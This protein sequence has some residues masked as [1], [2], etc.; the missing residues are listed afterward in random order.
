MSSDLLNSSF[1][2]GWNNFDCSMSFT[3]CA[4]YIRV[5]KQ[6]K[7]Q[8]PV[9][10]LDLWNDGKRAKT[11]SIV[12]TSNPWVLCMQRPKTPWCWGTH[13]SERRICYRKFSKQDTDV[14]YHP[15]SKQFTHYILYNPI[16]KRLSV[17]FSFKNT[18]VN[19]CHDR[20]IPP[21]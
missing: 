2:T 16:E 18:H 4:T 20:V 7:N 6:I 11:C 9:S 5:Q 12:M 21:M 19:F 13:S 8:N 14:L 10:Q 3:I 17:I 1:T 15:P